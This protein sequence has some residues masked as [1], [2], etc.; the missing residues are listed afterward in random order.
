MHCDAAVMR[1]LGGIFTEEQSLAYLARGLAHWDAH[2][3][4]VWIVYE[5]GGD[6]P[7]GRVVLRHMLLDGVD[8]I[9]TGYA[10]YQSHWG[11]GL[12]S[13]ITRACVS[14]GFEHLPCSSIVAVT[15]P[16]NAASQ[17]VL[18]KCGFVLD[19][20]FDR[21]GETLNLFRVT[22]GDHSATSA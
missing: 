13:E 15:A 10:F 17:R 7:I 18:A 20:A 8:E 6:T 22:A 2:R 21:S 4:G 12:A 5:R 14:L 11:R 1:H 16:A 19:R 9:E 3:L